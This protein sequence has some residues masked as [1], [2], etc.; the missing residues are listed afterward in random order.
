MPA[1]RC[2]FN[3]MIDRWKGEH[4]TY[5]QAIDG[6][7]SFEDVDIPDDALGQIDAYNQVTGEL[8]DLIAKA[9]ANGKTLRA[10]GSAWSLSK[11][12]VTEH[13]LLNTAALTIG[14]RPGPT[15]LHPGYDGAKLDRLRFLECGASIAS[16]NEYLH[17]EKLSLKASGSN[18]GQ[19]LAGVI[20]TGT[21]GSAYNFG[22]CQEFVVGLHLILGPTKHVYLQSLSNPV[23]N[24]SW[25]DKFGAAL[26]SDDTLFRSALVSFGSFGIIHG[27]MVETR[28]RFLLRSY[29][30]FE[31]LD[32]GLWDTIGTLNFDSINLPKPKDTLYHFEVF[33]NPNAGTPPNEAVVMMMFEEDWHDYTPPVWNA[34][35]GGLSASGLDIMGQ[36]VTSLPASVSG[37]IKS[38]LNDEVRRKFA[39]Y[40]KVGAIKDLFRGEVTRGKTLACG[41]G[42]PLDKAVQALNIAFDTYKN[43]GAVLPLLVSV[44]YVKGT[45]A[46]LGFTKFA[47]TCV[48]E[49][50]AVNVSE[51]RDYVKAVWKGLADAGINFTLH[52]GKFNTY[53]SAARVVNMYGQES[54]DKWKASRAA[55]MESIDVS[56]V[57]DNAFIKKAGLGT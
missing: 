30:R 41:V 56:R 36:L 57:F 14:L 27:V 48:L 49:L 2:S 12:G 54:V 11:C 44:R 22:A 5:N 17:G 4:Q 40:E 52:W 55:L 43:F 10:Y 28:D 13:E 26:L 23:V 50:D 39:P 24:Q 45:Q 38:S 32:A 6:V 35:T 15:H 46:T 29:R 33:F 21:H 42:L 34:G 9:V 20:S 31:P 7:H 8:C 37:L 18:S 25:C 3:N 16:I 1:T 19:S 47:T 53:L 51:T